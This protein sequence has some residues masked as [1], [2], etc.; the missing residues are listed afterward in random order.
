MSSGNASAVDV[1]LSAHDDT[2][3][4]ACNVAF[5]AADGFQLAMPFGDAPGHIGLGF[6][7]GPEPA[8]RND[9][10]RAVGRA[11]APAVQTMSDGLP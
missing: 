6:L 8:D 10:Q 5:Q 4:L 7:I 11:I 2:E 9:V 3:D 1:L